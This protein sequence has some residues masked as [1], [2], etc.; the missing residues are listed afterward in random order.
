[1]EKKHLTGRINE[2]GKVTGGMMKYE[3]VVNL[4]R[5]KLTGKYRR[6][7]TTVIRRNK[8][9]AK[10]AL[11][12]FIEEVESSTIIGKANGS[13]SFQAYSERWL[14]NRVLSGTKAKRTTD[15]E[16]HKI[17]RLNA[18]MG[19][20]KMS[21]IDSDLVNRVYAELRK[22][23]S[24]TSVSNIHK[25]LRT[26]MRD[27][28]K[29]GVAAKDAMESVIVP[30]RDTKSHKALSTNSIQD[31]I[32]AMNPEDPM[33]LAVL[34]CLMTGLRRSEALALTW[35]DIKGNMLQVSK[36]LD[37]DGVSKSPKSES[38]NR[39]IP[40][41]KALQEA[42]DIAWKAKSNEF[43]IIRA[44]MMKRSGVIVTEPSMKPTTPIVCTSAGT[45][46]KPHTLTAWWRKNKES[47]GCDCTIHDLRR[48]YLTELAR[49]K[50][51]PE[52]MRQL[53]GHSSVE[54]TMDIYTQVENEERISAMSC[55]DSFALC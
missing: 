6:T 40:I 36:A 55:F 23:L 25:T 51:N 27:A 30:K 46:Y 17:K 15:I 5:D 18:L 20:V 52:I 8:T 12:E 16:K 49:N 29:D 24:G 14:E 41:P 45:C 28:A 2:L 34:L 26:I 33:Q 19:H 22:E 1:M 53:A 4:G 50:V 42:L 38:G 3:L 54:V 9:A 48:S 39:P 13:T 32:K 35:D 43:A 31:V 11:R 21:D 7:T 10:A 47:F 44:D 37:E